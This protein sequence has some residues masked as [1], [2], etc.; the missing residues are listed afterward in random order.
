[1]K[2]KQ[3][4]KQIKLKLNGATT[5]SG[6]FQVTNE[7]TLESKD[8]KIV[9]GE[10]E[11]IGGENTGEASGLNL[12][13]IE[14]ENKAV[15]TGLAPRFGIIKGYNQTYISGQLGSVRNPDSENATL[16]VSANLNSYIS[17]LANTSL[18]SIYLKGASSET[19]IL[20][21]GIITPKLTQTSL[22]KQKKNF[23]K[24]DNALDIIQ[25]ID[26]YKYNLKFES[27]NE[28][29]HIGFVIGDNYNYAKEITSSDNK[30]VDLYSFVSL[31]C[32]AIQELAQQNK[33]LDEKI[34]TMEEK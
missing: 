27:D 24:M 7:G 29:K 21:S 19:S 9:G 10:I 13:V 25:N 28:K 18:A 23:T 2:V 1:M 26:I 15:Y 8:G 20:S 31:C 30:G 5:V 11:I 12:R 4:L 22:E 32:K 33:E 17:L 16:S 34:K 6:K 3:K 14:N